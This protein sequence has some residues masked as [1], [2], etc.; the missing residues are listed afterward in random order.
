VPHAK[1]TKG[2]CVPKADP[3]RTIVI[4][5][6]PSS[7]SFSVFC[8]LKHPSGLMD[9]S[10]LAIGHVLSHDQRNGLTLCDVIVGLVAANDSAGKQLKLTL[11]WNL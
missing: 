7:E 2:P 10:A 4:N 6:Q 8:L 5:A 1:K 3:L 11:P 9:S